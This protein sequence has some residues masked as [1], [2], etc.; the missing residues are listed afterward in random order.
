MKDILIIDPCPQ[1]RLCLTPF[2]KEQGYEP[3]FVPDAPS[4]LAAL[5]ERPFDLILLDTTEPALE[6]EKLLTTLRGLD[7]ERKQ[8][9][10]AFVGRGELEKERRLLDKGATACLTKPVDFH[11][12]TMLLDGLA[13]ISPR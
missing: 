10:V 9:L 5:W 11:D 7:P 12:M 1:T 6:G 8:T 2:L 3:N 4:A 13:A